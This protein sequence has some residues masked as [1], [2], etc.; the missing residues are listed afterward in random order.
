MTTDRV[1]IPDVTDGNNPV[2]PPL[3][4]TE[5]ILEQKLKWAVQHESEIRTKM[6]QLSFRQFA[7]LLAL[8]EQ[9]ETPPTTQ[10]IRM[11]NTRRGRNMSITGEDMQLLLKLALKG[12]RRQQLGL[13]IGN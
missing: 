12:L 9:A 7:A 6:R 13:Q 8:A 2:G 4:M 3:V 5:A 1:V 10:L 11:R